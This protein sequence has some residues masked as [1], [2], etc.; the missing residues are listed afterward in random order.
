M[1]KLVNVYGMPERRYEVRSEET[2]LDVQVHGQSKYIEMVE[3]LPEP[4][5]EKQIQEPKKIIKPKENISE[6]PQL[7]D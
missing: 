5:F 7:S 2:A 6:S 4:E 1:S 3:E